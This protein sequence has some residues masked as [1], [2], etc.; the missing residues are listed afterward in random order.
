MINAYLLLAAYTVRT[1]RVRDSMSTYFIRSVK[2]NALQPFISASAV[3]KIS[4]GISSL[5]TDN[6]FEY[7]LF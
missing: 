7:C 6:T 3:K 1:V 2:V 5:K 4:L